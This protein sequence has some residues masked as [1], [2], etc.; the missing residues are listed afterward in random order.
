MTKIKRLYL[1]SEAEI[2]DLYAQPN[3]N[4]DERELYFTMNQIELDALSHYS[5]TKTRVAFILQLAYFKAKRQFF[6][7]K[8]EDVSEDGGIAKAAIERSEG[9]EA[10]DNERG[11]A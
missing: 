8:F 4:S 10:V 11:V 1:L 2:E 7:F 5:T 6:T 9:E 3:F